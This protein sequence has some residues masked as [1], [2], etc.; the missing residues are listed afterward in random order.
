MEEHHKITWKIILIV[1]L[2]VC[3][4]YFFIFYL[5]ETTSSSSEKNDTNTT[6][7]NKHNSTEINE[8]ILLETDDFV[9]NEKIKRTQRVFTQGLLM[10]TPDTFIESGGLYG[11]ST[12]RR[13]SLNNP[14]KPLF[15]NSI[16]KDYFTE[17][18]TLFKGKIYQLTWREKIM[19]I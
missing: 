4:F 3:L 10:D 12:L 5:N 15:N 7:I 8:A 17:G 9:V 2:I 18:C 6:V 14:D 16:S 19:Y 1:T 11:K 13:F